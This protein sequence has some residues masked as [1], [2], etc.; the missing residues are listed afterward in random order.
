MK[1]AITVVLLLPAVLLAGCIE[2]K[3]PTPTVETI[4]VEFEAPPPPPP[5]PLATDAPPKKAQE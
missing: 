2:N 4:T 3:P 5:P 1:R